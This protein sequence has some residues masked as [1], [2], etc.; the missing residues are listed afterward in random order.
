MS[1]FILTKQTKRVMLSPEYLAQCT[2]YLLG[3]MDLINEQLVADIARRIVK[4]GALTESAQFEAE[5]LT[6]QNILYKDIVNSI[7]KVSGLTEAEITR[8]FEDAN[9]ENMESENLRAAIAGKT[10]LD[11]ASNVAMGNLL[12]SHIRKTK[13]VVRNLT[14]TTASQG[15]NAFINAVNLANMQVD[16]YPLYWT[17]SKEGIFMRYSHEYKLECIE[18]YRQGIWPETPEGIKPTRFRK[19]IRYWVRV[20]EQNGPD[21]LKHLG[22]NKVWT[23]EA[24]YEL[25]AKVL[26]GQSNKSVA[27][28]AGISDG[29]LYTWVRK[30]KELGY[31]GLVNKQKGRKNPGMKKKTIE[32]KPLTESEREELIRLRAEIAAMKAEIEVVKKRIALRQERWAAQLKAKKQQS[33]KR[34]EKKDTN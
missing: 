7:S 34:S 3:M 8:V 32:P 12:S 13:G 9:F 23:P 28:S 25:V 6:Q 22:N 18:L 17:P 33:S 2:S 29:M 24:K 20:E 10:P 15:Q 31:N 30:Y 26:A 11:H 27:I 5:K 19:M 21:A 4:M 1:F 16:M 14:R